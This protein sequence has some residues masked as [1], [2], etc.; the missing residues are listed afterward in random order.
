MVTIHILVR[1]RHTLWFRVNTGDLVHRLT[2]QIL[3][4]NNGDVYDTILML[5][6]VKI[7]LHFSNESSKEGTWSQSEIY[8]R[9]HLSR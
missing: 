8:F 3:R 9:V 1:T 6:F 2:S 4:H 7:I 5:Y